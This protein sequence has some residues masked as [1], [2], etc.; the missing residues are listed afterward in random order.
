MTIRD[1]NYS[2]QTSELESSYRQG[3]QV[4]LPLLVYGDGR[5]REPRRLWDTRK[6]LR[7]SRG[8]CF[9]SPGNLIVDPDY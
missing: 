3:W 8:A 5:T 6:C 7:A 2:A 9:L 1:I 4:E